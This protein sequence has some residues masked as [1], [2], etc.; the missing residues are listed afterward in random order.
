MDVI[1]DESSL[2]SCNGWSPAQRIQIMAATLKALDQLG[3]AR[4]LRSVR[5]A[6]DQDIGQ[7]RGL[8]GWCFDVGVN[9]DAGI[10]IAQRLGRQPFIDGA[11]GLFEGAEGN[12][13]IE[14]RVKG[15]HVI[16]LTLAALTGAP[17]VA[18]GSI[19]LPACTTVSVDLTTLDVGGEVQ[20]EIQVCCVVRDADVQQQSALIIER[21]EQA[22]TSGPHLL[23]RAEALFPR[24]RFG[25]KAVE[26]IAELTGN[27]Q[28][29]HQLLRHLRS[30]DKGAA[31]WQAEK[32]YCPAEAI[33]RSPESNETLNH[34]LYGPMRDFPMP[35]GFESRRWSTHTKLSGGAGAR[36]YFCAERTSKGPVVLIG[37][38]GGHLPTVRFGG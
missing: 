8:R 20:E 33:S 4:V 38:F 23:E 37:Y 22:V 36:M 13:A 18:L 7:G 34:R 15:T 32:Q 24:L 30:L 12:R 1:L 6:A 9:R 21:I 10:F 27:E 5:S 31:C 26:Q 25:P 17:A 11:G 3:C 29:F 28:V 14:G 19:V 35:N 16:G 2:L